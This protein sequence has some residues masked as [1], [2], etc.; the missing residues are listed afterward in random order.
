MA[1]FV[2]Y[3]LSLNSP[4]SYLGHR[5]FAALAEQHGLAVRLYP[6]DFAGIIFPATGGLPVGKRSPQRQ[7]YRLVELERWRRHLNVALN[8]HPRFWPA[9]EVL[10]AQ[11]V[12][13]ARESG[14]GTVTLAGALMQA[15][16]SEDR[17][18]ADRD[19]LLAVAQACD[20]DGEGL[21]AAADTTD[22]VEMRA[23]E[24]RQAIERGVF[25]APT[26]IYE[27]QPFWGQD[28]LDLL[29]LAIKGSR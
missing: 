5:R 26:Y 14:A 7:A 29:E 8:I 2:D 27:E 13:A 15:V 10:A 24:S 6:V 11:M 16:W 4:W 3:Y 1:A 12:L 17:N 25:G 9:D 19:I 28:R 18:I 21:L 20:L 22:M 23:D